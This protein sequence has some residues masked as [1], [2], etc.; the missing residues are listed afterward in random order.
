MMALYILRP[1]FEFFRKDGLKKEA[2]SGSESLPEMNV[3]LGLVHMVVTALTTC[4]G[5]GV[6]T[7]RSPQVNLRIP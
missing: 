3:Q 4:R 7:S 1:R 5:N 6:P 2:R